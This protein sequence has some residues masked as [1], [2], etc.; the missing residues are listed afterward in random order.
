MTLDAHDSLETIRFMNDCLY[1]MC[2]RTDECLK[3]IK[4]EEVDGLTKIVKLALKSLPIS[5]NQGKLN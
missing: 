5:L 4:D 1:M 3:I 2:V